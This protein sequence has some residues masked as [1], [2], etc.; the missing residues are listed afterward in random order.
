M[1]GCLEVRDVPET[2]WRQRLRNVISW[3]Y[4]LQTQV[5]IHKTLNI[6]ILLDYGQ[7]RK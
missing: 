3:K 2:F 1:Y 4:T 7:N 5:S 6:I